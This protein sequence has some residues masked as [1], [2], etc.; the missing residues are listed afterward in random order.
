M[1]GDR[2]AL[3]EWVRNHDEK[4]LFVVLYLGLAVGLSVF[5]SLFW[6][7]AVA[8][9]HL[10]LECVRQAHYRQG[11]SNVFLHALWEVKLDVGLVLLALV[12]VLYIDMVMGLLGVQSAARAAAITR[13]GTRLGSRVAAWERTLRT[14]LLTIDEMVRIAHAAL[15]LRRRARSAALEAVVNSETGADTG[16]EARSR[17]VAVP[18]LAHQPDMVSHHVAGVALDRAA[19]EDT[20][21]YHGTIN[22]ARHDAVES[23]IAEGETTEGETTEGA[24]A[25]DDPVDT[26]TSRPGARAASNPG[27][28][29]EKAVWRERWTMGDKIAVVLVA[30]GIVLVG[31]APHLTPHDWSTAMK[32]LLAE[33][34]PFP[35]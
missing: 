3:R 24:I 14:L 29:Y 12:L 30:C 8:G 15:M 2:Q 1:A 21:A 16:F 10:I 22:D 11:R 13:A 25:G 6:L 17:S 28:S 23:A 20:A 7:V 27:P 26:V 19:A 34:R 33:L 9:A 32:T 31:A 4:W 35:S 18:A 5:V